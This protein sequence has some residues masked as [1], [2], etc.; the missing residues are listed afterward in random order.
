MCETAFRNKGGKMASPTTVYNGI[1]AKWGVSDCGNL[2]GKTSEAGLASKEPEGTYEHLAVGVLEEGYTLC[3]KVQGNDKI[4]YDVYQEQ[5][6]IV[7]KSNEICRNNNDEL[8]KTTV[9]ETDDGLIR[10]QQTFIISGN[11]TRVVIRMAITNCSRKVD[12]DDVLIKRYADLDVDTGGT[13]GWAGFQAHWD[14]NRDSVFSYN[15]DGDAPKGKRAHVVNMVAM[16]SDLPLDDT[17]VGRL[18][19]KQYKFRNNPSPIATP[20]TTRM[21][22]D[23]ILQWHASKFRCGECFRINMYYDAFRS[24]AA[25]PGDTKPKPKPLPNF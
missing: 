17:F 25:H 21:D 12:L 18:G 2:I 13:A 8:V 23:G 7:C 15:L 3:Y 19:A 14:K 22:G 11:G 20:T 6:G 5:D 1:R 4:K 16:P 10:I 9:S 24:W